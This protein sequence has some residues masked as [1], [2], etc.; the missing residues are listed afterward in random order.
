MPS[1]VRAQ[2]L[3]GSVVGTVKDAQGAAIP[4]AT[5]L[6]TNK[7]TNSTREVV[8]GGE[9]EY[10]LANVLPGHYDVKVT[11]TGFREFI[12]TNVPVSAGQIS[13]VDVKLDI[14]ALTET[15]TVASDAQLLQTDKSDLHTEL[16]SKEITNLPLNQYRNYQALINLVPGASPATFQN[17][18]TDTP[19][20]ALRTN[21][22]G[23][24]GQNN[25]TRIDGASS[26]N[27]WLPHH[28]GYI[29]PAET[30]ETVN[31]STNNFD[32][33]QGMA[34]G[35]SVTVV[36]KSGTNQVKGSAFYFRNQ[37][38]LNATPFFT[39]S[40]D[41]TPK[42]A[43][44]KLNSSIS[45]G[46]GTVGGP[47]VRNKLFFFGGYEGNYERNSRF[48][49]SNAAFSVPTAKIRNGD[50]SE[51]LAINP[52][53][54]IYDPATG[55]PD[56]T[57]RTEFPGAIIPADR[58][59]SIAR[60][61]Q[62]L[63]P[64]PNNPGTNNGLLNNL[65]LPRDPKADR[66]NYDFKVDWNRTS[67]HHIFV[68]YSTLR[69]KV[70]DIFKLGYDGV[71]FG[72]TKI[73]VPTAGH[74]W[75]ISPT[76]VLDGA[77]GMNKQNQFAHGGD[78]G[79]NF[80]SETFGIP[81]TN[82]PDPRQSGMPQFNTGYTALGNTDSWVPMER[83][84]TSYTITSNLTKMMGRHEI[85]SGFD[86]IR[87]QLDHWQPE[88][89]AGPRGLFDF[90]GNITGQ[91]GYTAN[92]TWNSYAAFLLGLDSGNSKSI[93]YETM[94]GRE[95]QYAVFVS[96]RWN[97]SSKVTVN[98][99]LRYEYYPLMTRANHGLERLDYTTW[100]VLIGGLGNVPEDNG[101]KV[102]KTLFAP[103]L[104]LAY[105]INDK[106][107]F[108]TGYGLTY[109]PIPWSRPMRLSY[110]STIGF[111]QTASGVFGSNFAS[112]PLSAGIPNIPLPDISNGVIPMP[113]NVQTRTPNPTDVDRGR[114]Q[115]WNV[116]MERQLPMDVSVSI[117]YVGTRTDG[118]YADINVNYADPGGGDAG[119]KLFAVAGTAEIDDWAGRT[120]RRYNA[121]QTAI[122]RPFKNGLLLKGAYTWSK[123]MDETDDDGWVGLSWSQPSQ[124]S[125]NYAL[126][127]YDRTH[128]F[129]M[130]FLYDLPF[131]KN[132]TGILPAIV[133]NWQVNGVYQFYSGNPFTIGG[134][135]T[136]LN[137]RGGQQT[138]QQISEIRR[139]GPA[140]PN[141]VYYDPASF[142][143]PGNQWGNTG[144][145]FLRGPSNYNLDM[146]VFRGF[147]VG[148]YRVEFRMTASNVLN[149]V[150]WGN[151][152]TSFTDPNFMKIRSIP[153]SFGPRQIQLGLRF[154]F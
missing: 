149:H 89:G 101:I 56:G 45:I 27:I 54:H 37:D 99:G 62:A 147:P 4:A 69:A 10:T 76:M 141:A 65:Y 12:Q 58:I 50:F 66:D 57:G 150:R 154:Q 88:L 60:Q 135:N 90:S 53:F 127:G 7:E 6:I 112:F 145:N 118:G 46:G 39:P 74:T 44:G 55:N 38:E 130:G 40:W 32:A 113:R 31:V 33:A 108:R 71:G 25:N 95:N 117:A 34:G 124:L 14:G 16:K 129:S 93:Q 59:S 43:C 29:A 17:A 122:N 42:P 9:G 125:R 41:V 13:R 111:S 139:V 79:T 75:T 19:G 97:A 115:Q 23:A 72:D 36:T 148:H 126:A 91:P 143:Q 28:A 8:T 77:V 144:R 128:N 67:T 132:D 26:V 70:S 137:Q 80:G 1:A 35:A 85:R 107:V 140:G 104:G 87:Y 121:L 153:A 73:Y 21:I 123:A 24:D 51:V 103:R 96:D 3:Y 152:V 11:L 78:F 20:R 49:D 92:S 5:V 15:V 106:T 82:G 120:K 146:G 138:I 83:H 47:I 105:R 63:Y 131:A 151:P 102:S 133:Q 30:I 18:Q 22:N 98:A 109:D 81:G 64:L 48:N 114:S 100:N 119:R 134:D 52:N 68:K 136:A 2:V 110:P 94:T 116:T 84:E 142:A 86:F 61:V